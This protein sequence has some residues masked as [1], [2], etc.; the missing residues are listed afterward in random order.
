MILC[1]FN[2]QIACDPIP[3]RSKVDLKQV[4]K[5][6]AIMYSGKIGKK[7]PI[8]I[9]IKRRSNKLNGILFNSFQ[10]KKK[11]TGRMFFNEFF[12]LKEFE[13]GKESG[14]FFGRFFG[15]NKILGVWTTPDGKSAFPF[16]LLKKKQY[17]PGNS[18]NLNPALDIKINRKSVKLKI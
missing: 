5:E 13:K 17:V 8:Q 3:G 1:F 10:M 14:S 7:F 18:K 15:H 4:I 6:V 11:V 12:Y 16:Y 2:L 9:D